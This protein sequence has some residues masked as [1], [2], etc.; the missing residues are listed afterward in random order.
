MLRH[1]VNHDKY[2]TTSYV[3]KRGKTFT[4]YRVPFW[5]WTL[6]T[7]VLYL[8]ITSASTKPVFLR[9]T[10]W[11]ISITL[12]RRGNKIKTYKK[13]INHF[14][15]SNKRQLKLDSFGLFLKT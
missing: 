9:K 5:L 13:T 14:S 1:Q 4:K 11:T 3:Y 12:S 10:A 7:K 15:N 8:P 2:N 6:I